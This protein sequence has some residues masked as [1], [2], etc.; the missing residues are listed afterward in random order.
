MTSP[1]SS[2]ASD[3]RSPDMLTSPAIASSLEP[4]RK[5]SGFSIS[6]ILG[7]AKSTCSTPPPDERTPDAVV[8]SPVHDVDE[9]TVT[10]SPPAIKRESHDEEMTSRVAAAPTDVSKY[11]HLL[12]HFAASQTGAADFRQLYR[13]PLLWNP[14]L[15]SALHGQP[16]H[17]AVQRP[18][19]FYPPPHANLGE[20]KKNL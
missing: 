14:W 18:P 20:S 6:C 12:A 10:S 7:D 19:L 16:L 13:W 15:T 11:N 9:P 3:T 17:G 2:P 4:N 1:V 8:T 5:A